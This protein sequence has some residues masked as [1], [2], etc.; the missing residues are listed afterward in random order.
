MPQSRQACRSS[1]G[2]FSNPKRRSNR[3]PAS[4]VASPGHATRWPEQLIVYLKNV[5]VPVPEMFA[6]FAKFANFE[7][8]TR[9]GRGAIP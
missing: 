9:Y 8:I 6:K 2:L 1:P 3:R 5:L 4:R 7:P